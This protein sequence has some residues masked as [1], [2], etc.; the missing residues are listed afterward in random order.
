MIPLK[1][2][3]LFPT[4]IPWNIT[5]L[6]I[7]LGHAQVY[8]T[9]EKTIYQI[10]PLLWSTILQVFLE[11]TSLT[12]QHNQALHFTQFFF[13]HGIYHNLPLYIY[14]HVGNYHGHHA[15]LVFK[16]SEFRKYIPNFLIYCYWKLLS[17]FLIYSQCQA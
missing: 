10:F 12:H 7:F 13:P 14:L 15:S 17:N 4:H 11:K 9:V 5:K 1:I 8:P 2:Y 3:I 6:F 16:P